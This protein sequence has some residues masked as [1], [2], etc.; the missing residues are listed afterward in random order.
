MGL[1]PQPAGAH[2]GRRDPLRGPRAARRCRRASM[3]DLRGNGI[4]MIFQ[5]PMT[6]LNPAFTIGEQIVEGLLRHRRDRP[7]R[8]AAQRAIEMLRARA[9]PGARAALRRVSAPALGRHAPARDDRD[10]ARLR[11]AP[12]DRRRAD[13]RARR[14]DP[15]A[16]PRADAH[17]AATRPARRSSSSRTTSASS[18]RSP[19]RS[20]VMYAGRIVERAPVAGAVRDAAASVHGRPARLDPAAATCEQRAA[21]GDRGPGAE[22]A[23]ARR[24]GCRF[25]DRCPFADRAVPRRGSPPLRD[26]GAGARVG[27]LARA[28]R[29]DALLARRCEARDRMSAPA[30]AGRGP[31]QALPGAARRV[32]PRR[33]ARCARSTA[34]TFDDRGRRDA[35]RS[36]AN[37]A[38]ASRRSAAW[39]CA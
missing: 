2:R 31:G 39:C 14:H 38:A 22:S 1:V 27:L 3:R 20:S 5:E 17:A 23:A 6:S 32:R 19:T 9:H 15:G 25:A 21:R 7:R 18:P 24:P 10:G 37:R 16:D 36:S 12:A 26:V 4:A 13:D 33:A 28:A 30:A 35:R 34:S 11:A 29:P 8:G